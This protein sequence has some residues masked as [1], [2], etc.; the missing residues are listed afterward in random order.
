MKITI[1]IICVV[2]SVVWLLV[3][4]NSQA[5]DYTNIELC[6]ENENVD[7]SITEIIPEIIT[8]IDIS[9]FHEISEIPQNVLNAGAFNSVA[10]EASIGFRH[11]NKQYFFNYYFTEISVWDTDFSTRVHLY[12]SLSDDKGD[13]I[14]FIGEYVG[15]PYL[16]SMPTYDYGIERETFGYC[17][18]WFGGGGLEFFLAVVNDELFIYEVEIGYESQKF[19]SPEPVPVLIGAI[20][21]R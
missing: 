7:G 21:L 11:E 6:V 20:E 8:E 2:L 5:T 16:V 19:E 4:C 17:R 12:F 1:K 3:A 10:D 18:T 15:I 9:T 14:Y 13:R